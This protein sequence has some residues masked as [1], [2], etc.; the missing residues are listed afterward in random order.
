MRHKILTPVFIL[1]PLVALLAMLGQLEASRKAGMPWR[2]EIEGY[3]P[4]D[5][6]R[7]HYLTFQ[8]QWA[9]E[10]EEPSSFPQKLCLNAGYTSPKTPR[11]SP[12]TSGKSCASILSGQELVHSKVYIPEAQA[13]DL[14]RKL[15]E[16]VPMAVDIRART[17]GSIMVE[18]LVV[19]GHPLKAHLQ[20]TGEHL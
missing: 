16:G 8:Y 6:L 5:M 15:R 11:V 2:V 3:D 19:D 1:V 9:W 14:E 4:R 17:D 12:Y 10:G 18:D 13:K 7:G 20:F